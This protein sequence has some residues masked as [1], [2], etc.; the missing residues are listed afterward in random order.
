MICVC[1]TAPLISVNTVEAK[2]GQVGNVQTS[3]FERADEDTVVC[4]MDGIPITKSKVDENG[5]IDM[6]IGEELVKESNA[7]LADTYS[8]E[9]VNK[10]AKVTTK[11]Y[12]DTQK[13]PIKTTKKCSLYLSKY[14]NAVIRTNI[15]ASRYSQ[16][17]T[18]LYLT[19]KQGVRFARKIETGFAESAIFTALGFVPK[20]GPTITIAYW[21]FSSYKSSV[22][23]KIRK[24]TDKG[25]KVRVN[26]A[27]SP[28]GTFY[29]VSE[30]KG[31][32]CPMVEVQ[33]TNNGGKE[34]LLSVMLKK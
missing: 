6:N 25:K 30:W 33:A 9:K 3:E 27:T 5:F 29:G 14:N 2:N 4:Y 32:T 13:L 19:A 16:Q 22:V 1:L 10:G 28:Y 23:L 15:T 18:K 7:N 24:Y 20:V 21:V 17:N 26:I 12:K 31:K 8:L 34:Q 11:V